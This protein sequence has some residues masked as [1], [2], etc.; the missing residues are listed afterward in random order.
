[1]TALEI[2]FHQS[3]SCWTVCRADGEAI[4]I[5]GTVPSPRQAFAGQAWFLAS[6]EIYDF[7]RQW[8]RLSKIC[9]V[10]MFDE[11]EVLFNVMDDRNKIERR[12]VEWMGFEFLWLDASFG[13]QKRPFWLFAKC[14]DEASREKYK[15]MLDQIRSKDK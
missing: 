1:M 4:A 10:E 12:W 6:P 15:P 9:L 7:R 8:V 14:R 2:S 13:P 5:F 3:S 11:F